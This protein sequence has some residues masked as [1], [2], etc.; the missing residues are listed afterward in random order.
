MQKEE[1]CVCFF[2]FFFLN[3]SVIQPR[4][5]RERVVHES[6]AKQR[7]SEFDNNRQFA[8]SV[9]RIVIEDDS[10]G[11]SVTKTR[12][13]RKKDKEEKKDK[14]NVKKAEREE[15]TQE[16]KTQ[17]VMFQ[18]LCDKYSFDLNRVQWD[19]ELENNGEFRQLLLQILN[20]IL[21]NNFE[22]LFRRLFK[23]LSNRCKNGILRK[24][25]IE[26][27]YVII[28][29]SDRKLIKVGNFFFMLAYHPT[30][31]G[32]FQFT[33]QQFRRKFGEQTF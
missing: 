5:D 14:D 7:S 20:E 29:E 22:D 25:F 1:K 30:P 17:E 19:R 26:E 23:V 10:D 32:I 9:A 3:I 28:R 12:R 2:L 13:G 8:G 6:G 16:E 33:I 21:L 4:P 11:I 31:V 15:K 18:A 24:L 27:Q